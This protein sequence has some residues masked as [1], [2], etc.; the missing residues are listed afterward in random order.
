MERLESIEGA[1]NL[2]FN[3]FEKKII[4]KASKIFEK[5][6]KKGNEN[7][8]FDELMKM[9]IA[10]EI[11][12]EFDVPAVKEQLEFYINKI[13]YDDII[14]PEIRHIDDNRLLEILDTKGYGC[15]FSWQNAISEKYVEKVINEIERGYK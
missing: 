2:K 3:H 7:L 13:I 15:L 8:I 1:I 11:N 5:E 4:E 9:P 14:E 12:E 10:D 6:F